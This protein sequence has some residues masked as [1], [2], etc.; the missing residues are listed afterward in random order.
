MKDDDAGAT[1]L[2]VEELRERYRIEREKRM[3]SDGTDQ[4]GELAGA[5]ADLDRD[6]YTER[7]ERQSVV[8]E[9]EVVVVGAGFGG[10]L[11]AIDLTKLGID[12]FRIVEKAGDFGGT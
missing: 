9:T 1:D 7:V 12:D 3:R 6:P 11:T 8:E 10:M 5:L 4:Y 2:R